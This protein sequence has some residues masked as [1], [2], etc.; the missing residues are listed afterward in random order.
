LQIFVGTYNCSFR[1]ELAMVIYVFISAGQWNLRALTSD[2][3][4]SNLPSEYGPWQRA[5]SKPALLLAK[6]KD[7]VHS[8]ITRSGFLL[9]SGNLGRRNVAS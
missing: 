9:L 5:E 7:P 8:A 1:I 2:A 3:S 6:A 4:G